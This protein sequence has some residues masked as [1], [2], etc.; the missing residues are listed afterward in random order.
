MDSATIYVPSNGYAYIDSSTL[1]SRIVGTVPAG[2]SVDHI[3]WQ[4][5]DNRRDNLRIATMSEQNSN[6]AERVDKKPPP[7]ELISLGIHRLPRRLRWDSGECKFVVDLPNTQI[8]GTK[9]TQVSMVNRFRD[10]LLKL[11]A[12]L[13]EEEGSHGDVIDTRITLA[14][15]YNQLV[16][17][18]HLAAP[19]V[20]PDGP[21][22]DIETMCG[23]LMYCRSCLGKLPALLHGERLHGFLNV[24]SGILELPQINCIAI[25]KLTNDGQRR[26]ILFD[27]VF[28]DT[29]IRLPACDI[30]GSSPVM[31]ATKALK[32]QFP[33]MVSETD[34]AA[35]KKFQLK[36]L[37][38]MNWLGRIKPD[39]HTLV[40]LNYQ[41]YD[42]RGENL[43]ALPGASKEHK[44]PE[45]IPS[46]PE[47]VNIGMRFW[48][49]G[50]SLATTAGRSKTS[51]W[52]LYVRG[53][54]RRN[55]FSCSPATVADVFRDKVLPLLAKL[56][57]EFEESNALYQRLLATWVSAIEMK[58]SELSI[59]T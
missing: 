5:A 18:A 53:P 51:P 21:Y 17:A 40:P 12:M 7:P 11:I 59:S 24:A 50:M 22:A 20:F 30:S 29:V 36:D 23:E 3:N 49:R 8:S 57:P 43:V 9:S 52:V 45:G 54:D 32:D 39:D 10:C 4:K 58:G 41:Q 15:E 1:H 31:V 14:D 56:I 25:V 26:I 6:R 55:S 38:W 48:P 34:V 27:D 47:S 33:Q 13:E 44:S 35:K 42:L 37:V 19:D 28:R 16:Q 46:V 2:F